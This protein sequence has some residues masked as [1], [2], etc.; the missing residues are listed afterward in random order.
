VQNNPDPT[1]INT[2]SLITLSVVIPTFNDEAA[3]GKTL[4]AV[5]PSTAAAQTKP[6]RLSKAIKI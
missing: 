5:S 1:F 3:I 6:S 2:K 4:D